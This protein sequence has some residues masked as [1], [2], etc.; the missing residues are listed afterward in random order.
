[1]LLSMVTGIA[2][3]VAASFHGNP[4]PRSTDL[5]E[6]TD[7]VHRIGDQYVDPVAEEDLVKNAIK[8][9]MQGLD[10][11]STFLDEAALAD[12]S[13][14]TRGRFAGVG[15]ELGFLDGWVKV[16]APVDGSPAA[17]AGLAAGDTLIAIDGESLKGKSLAES[18]HALRGDVGTQVQ[19][20]VRRDDDTTPSFTLTRAFVNLVSV[21]ARSIEQG[22]GYVRISHFQETTG[23]EL[24]RAIGK[25]LEEN[26]GALDGLVL[27]LRNNPGGVL[28]ASVAVADAFLTSGLIVYTEGRQASTHLRFRASGRDLI[29]GAPLAV[30][31]NKGS[32]SASEIVAGA[33]QDHARAVIVGMPSYGKGSVQT[34]LPLEHD[35]AVKLTTAHY[36]TPK[37]RSIQHQGITPDVVIDAPRVSLEGDV[38]L[39]EALK[40]LRDS[41][42]G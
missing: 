22:Y 1:M 42:R 17:L 23:S 32:A 34:V 25:V 26:G 10:A 4:M 36:F 8:G 18:V 15:I 37:G 6:F 16:V 24:E 20:Q 39:A 3:G 5:D 27:D 21:R 35:R 13:E 28:Q 12:L 31:I 33:L 29:G 11:H 19:V 9:M 2:L 40:Y 38:L 41:P 30:L 7:L 14:Q